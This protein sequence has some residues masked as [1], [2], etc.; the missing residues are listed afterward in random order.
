MKIPVDEHK[1][2][3]LM[4]EIDCE[5]TASGYDIPERPITALGVVSNRFGISMPI[6]KPHPGAAKQL[7]LNWPITER[8]LEWY[9]EQYG[10]RLKVDYSPGPDGDQDRWRSLG[11]AFSSNFWVSQFCCFQ[12]EDW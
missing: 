2:Y 5:L 9:S 3:E 7:V 12:D 1:F 11:A 8:I 10:E 6:T 4:H